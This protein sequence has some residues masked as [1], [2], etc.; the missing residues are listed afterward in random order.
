MALEEVLA[1]ISQQEGTIRGLESAILSARSPRSQTGAVG[2]P[3]LEVPPGDTAA[4]SWCDSI[5]LAAGS[6]FQQSQ[7]R[8]TSPC[9]ARVYSRHRRASR[10]SPPRKRCLQPSAHSSSGAP[11]PADACNSR[12]RECRMAEGPMSSSKESHRSKGWLVR[13]LAAPWV[14]HALAEHPGRE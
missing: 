14:P 13:P 4:S 6:L 12:R 7:T 5:E 1:R 10:T 3:V 2:S 11:L 8:P 9:L